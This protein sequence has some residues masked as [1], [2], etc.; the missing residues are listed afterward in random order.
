MANNTYV[1]VHGA[2]LGKFCWAKV[3]AILEAMG[4]AVL[5]LDLPA[6]GD[7]ATLPE[8]TS[9]ASYRDAVIGLI[10]DRIDRSISFGNIRN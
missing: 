2:W 5:A 9:L 8:K 10:G 1:L 3:V 6:H 4:H 7:D